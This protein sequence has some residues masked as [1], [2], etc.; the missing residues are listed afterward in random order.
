M[1]LTFPPSPRILP[2]MSNNEVLTIPPRVPAHLA[3]VLYRSYD[4]SSNY[5]V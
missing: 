3:R 5:A 4:F 2:L 1:L